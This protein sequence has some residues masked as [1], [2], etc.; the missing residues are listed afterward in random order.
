MNK[1][2]LLLIVVVLICALSLLEQAVLFK[3]T[4]SF[5]NLFFSITFVVVTLF[6]SWVLAQD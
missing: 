1:Y 2:R 3:E 6:A 4:G 5:T